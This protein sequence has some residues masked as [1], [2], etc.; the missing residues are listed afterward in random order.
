MWYQMTYMKYVMFT[1][2]NIKYFWKQFFSMSL[3]SQRKSS[4]KCEILA[5]L[6]F[7]PNQIQS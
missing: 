3:R 5:D 4:I 7:L 2:L 1:W 6:N